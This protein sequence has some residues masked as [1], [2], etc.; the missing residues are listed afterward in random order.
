MVFGANNATRLAGRDFATPDLD[1]IHDAE[2]FI[3]Y[4]NSQGITLW[5][6]PWWSANNLDKSAGAE[7]MRRWTRY[8]VHRLAAYNV[9][10]NVGGEYN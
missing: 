8:V 7:K 9:I 3:A 10:W 4:A 1:A 5:I 6:M 2:R